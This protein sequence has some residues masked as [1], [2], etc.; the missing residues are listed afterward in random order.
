M[1]TLPAQARDQIT[2][3]KSS[4]PAWTIAMLGTSKK[5]YKVIS[6]RSRAEPN[7]QIL[8]IGTSDLHRRV[9][10]GFAFSGSALIGPR[11]MRRAQPG[12]GRS[13]QI[14]G[15]GGNHHAGS[16]GQIESFAGGEIY[17]RLGLVIAGGLCTEHRVPRKTVATREVDHQR[18]VAVRYRGKHEPTLE[19]RQAARR[20]MPCVEAMPAEIELARYVLAQA[21]DAKARQNAVEIAPVQ[22]VELAER[23]LS[24]AHLLHRRLI[25]VPPRIGKGEASE[26]VAERLENALGFARHSG[27]PIDE[28]AEDVKEQRAD[29]DH[30]DSMPLALSTPAAAGPLSTSTRAFAPAGSFAVAETAAA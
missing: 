1:P 5:A 14:G 13:K 24:G 27:A 11:D 15:M 9:R 18:D 8:Q 29:R 30:G 3:G 6:L 20:V 7:G 2:M 4:H 17:A 28:R 26:S 12:F 19:A 25:L 23:D 10:F 22:Q 21:R 16:R